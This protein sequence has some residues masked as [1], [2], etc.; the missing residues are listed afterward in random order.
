[1]IKKVIISTYL[2]NHYK[3]GLSMKKITLFFAVLFLPFALFSQIRL[4]FRL[5]GV[6]KSKDS[7]PTFFVA[8]SF[9]N[10]NPGDSSYSFK[11]IA[12][13]FELIKN[14]PG[15]N[16]EYKITRGNWEKAESDAEGNPKANRSLKLVKDTIVYISVLNWAD[17]FEKEPI[18]HTASKN[19]K[20]LDS[21][22]FIPQLN[23]KRRVWIYLPPS[24]S[25]S[26]KSYPVIYMHDG[27]NLFDA[28]TS[29]FGEWKIDEFL[30]SVALKGGKEFIVVGVDHGGTERLTEYNPYD[31]EYG[32]GK[33]KRYVAFLA[34][35]LK[36]FVDKNY[37][38]KSDFKY[39]TVAGSSMGGL[40]SMYAVTEFPKVFGNAGVFSP[41]FWIA[42]KMIDDLKSGV[43]KLKAHK[44][45]FVAGALE[46]EK[47]LIDMENVYGILNSL[48]KNEN[49][50]L[51]DKAD[52]KHQE[53]F[54]ARE[55]ADFYK[56]IAK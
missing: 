47:M 27:Q 31:S 14:I 23:K 10:W 39:T 22:F 11:R 1:M 50:V 40:I 28:A 6:P 53:W 45:Y 36:P 54:W 3:L 9:N 52:G 37:R 21:A 43:S 42:K 49:V 19:V 20:L 30:D 17:E 56:F 29:G 25:T 2:L 33:G 4:T 34:E 35:T 26:K 32:P 13:Q 8:G 44:I 55:F 7:L 46:S 5:N 38:T 12:D 24:Y 15:G 51:V 18:K 48:G 41:A 16:Y